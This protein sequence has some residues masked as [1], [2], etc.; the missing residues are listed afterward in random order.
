MACSF[1][2]AAATWRHA[3]PWLVLAAAHHEV[4]RAGRLRW[5]RGLP[6]PLLARWPVRGGGDDKFGAVEELS[7]VDAL[8]ALTEATSVILTDAGCDDLAVSAMVEVTAHMLPV[9]GRCGLRWD[10]ATVEVAD[11]CTF[12]YPGMCLLPH[13]E[14]ENCVIPANQLCRVLWVK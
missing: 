14:C 8:A 3:H 1:I 11:S 6:N 4:R 9:C 5:K 7:P 10:R 2:D 12:R 13:D